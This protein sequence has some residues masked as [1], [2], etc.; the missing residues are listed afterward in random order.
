MKERKRDTH[1]LFFKERRQVERE[2][3][4]QTRGCTKEAGRRKQVGTAGSLSPW[5][6]H[7]VPQ[8][9][10]EMLQGLPSLGPVY[11]PVRPC[12]RHV[13]CIHLYLPIPGSS[14]DLS[15]GDSA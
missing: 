13:S 12:G 11:V 1:E 10:D 5:H 3:I 2:E 6:L 9:G 8:A 15:A 14:K 4:K 7:P